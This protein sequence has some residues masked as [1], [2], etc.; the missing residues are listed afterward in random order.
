MTGFLLGIVP[1]GLFIWSASQNTVFNGF[2]FGMA[3]IG[4]VSPY[5]DVYNVIMV[6]KQTKNTDRIMFVGDDTYRIS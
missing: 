3:G 4:M 5:S 2:M 6:L 1:L